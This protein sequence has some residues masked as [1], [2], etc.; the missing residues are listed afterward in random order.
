MPIRQSQRSTQ[1]A[2]EVGHARC[3]RRKV[4]DVGQQG[5]LQPQMITQRILGKRVDDQMLHRGQIGREGFG[6][7]IRDTVDRKPFSLP[8]EI[9]VVA[10][11]GDA[12]SLQCNR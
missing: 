11:G 12:G 6:Q 2:V 7:Q 4:E 9:V 8:I 10:Q 1:I 5:A 3:G